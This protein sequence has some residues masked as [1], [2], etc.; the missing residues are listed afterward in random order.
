M[1]PT[2]SSIHQ[3]AESARDVAP[4]AR[5]LCLQEA[6]DCERVITSEL[7]AALAGTNGAVILLDDALRIR[8]YTPAVQPL[9]RLIPS[10][11]G[12]PLS[13]LRSIVGDTDLVFDALRVLKQ[14]PISER[15]FHSVHDKWYLRRVL[16]YRGHDLRIAGVA[17][18]FIDITE[19]KLAEQQ[20]AE[21]RRSAD[22]AS[23][24]KSRF[25]ATASHDLRQ[26]VQ[27][28]ILLVDLLDRSVKEQTAG[29]LVGRM[30]RAVSTIVGKLNALIDL[31]HL[32]TDT[33][34]ADVSSFP[35]GSVLE[36]LNETL[37]HL[38]ES[39]HLELRVVGSDVVVRS[40][41]RLL[42]Q[43]LGNL[44]TNA[45]AYTV[46]GG[47]LV[48]CRK[49]SGMLRIEVWDTGVG[50][51]EHELIRIFDEYHQLENAS[52]ER[53]RGLGLG[54]SLVKQLADRL[55]HP[56]SVRSRLGKGSVFTV[57][58]P[59]SS[60]DEVRSM[61]NNRIH[62]CEES[63][64]AQTHLLLVEDDPDILT[65]LEALF[66]DSGYRVTAASTLDSA[67]QHFDEFRERADIVFADYNL[68]DGATGVQVVHAMRARFGHSL[69]AVIFTGDTSPEVVGILAQNDCV[70]L[71][72]PVNFGEALR[73]V[74]RALTGSN[75]K[76]APHQRGSDGEEAGRP[77]VYVV[78]DD[79][80]LRESLCELLVLN[81]YAALPYASCEL[82][83][84]NY[85]IQGAACLIIDAYLPGMTGI[86]L[87]DEL[88]ATGRLLPSIMIT[89]LGDI[90]TAVDAMKAGAVE[91]I[92][93]PFVPSYLL[94]ALA[95]ALLRSQSARD[96]NALRKIAVDHVGALTPR[97]VQIMTLVVAGQPSKSIA[98]TLHISQRTVEKHRAEIMR[99]MG[100]HSLPELTR[101][102][103]L[104][105]RSTA[106]PV[107]VTAHG[108]R[109]HSSTGTASGT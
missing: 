24:V 15:E 76:P 42:E 84:A 80:Q 29:S 103:L 71:R 22:H 51:P 9:L 74:E 60:A 93:K 92:E 43:I 59:I 90:A 56:I 68:S 33:V 91:F 53:T 8:F 85:H 109:Y 18:S 88:Q 79:P 54:L 52:R 39:K 19:L 101:S 69:P 30:K 1:I 13:D 82:F 28:L 47:V 89:G 87:L 35:I 61:R 75:T 99:R 20:I 55:G 34:S 64:R 11:I 67:L 72:K 36:R 27:N 17:V 38:A 62:T 4:L 6:L 98:S 107:G 5:E 10:D 102:A 66:S 96:E 23:V 50:I 97:Q 94:S 78:D 21:A 105:A 48:G 7:R 104:G 86:E 14:V 40:N 44:I 65:L 46:K 106:S 70:H 95:S 83:L 45:L 58:V 81:G 26:P 77:T 16:P 49:S 3:E 31:N 108:T 63:A 32:A 57:H 2:Q 12:R 37:A 25:I 100:A 41:P 73:A